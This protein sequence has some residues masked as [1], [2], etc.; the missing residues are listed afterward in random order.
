[1]SQAR[2]IR[3]MATSLMDITLSES[4]REVPLTE[5]PGREAL[6]STSQLG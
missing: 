1:M 3:R 6:L 4:S 2:A 5:H